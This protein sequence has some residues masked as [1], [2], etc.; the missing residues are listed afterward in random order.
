M[1]KSQCTRGDCRWAWR[2]DAVGVRFRGDRFRAGDFLTGVWTL[3]CSEEWEF[4]VVV[5]GASICS[6]VAKTSVIGGLVLASVLRH[7]RESV[8]AMKAPFCGYCPSNLVSM[9]RNSLRLSLKYGFAQST[10]F[11]SIPDIVLSTARL[12][13]KSSSNTTP[14]L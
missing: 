1:F 6:R 11:C 8:A 3:W 2:G 13:D 9:I 12:P 10:R 7:C 14:K 5:L 4:L